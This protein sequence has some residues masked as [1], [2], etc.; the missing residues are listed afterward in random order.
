MCS[1]NVGFQK[2]KTEQPVTPIKQNSL[3]FKEPTEKCAIN[4]EVMGEK[5]VIV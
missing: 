1:E 2:L 4:R 5:I 3:D